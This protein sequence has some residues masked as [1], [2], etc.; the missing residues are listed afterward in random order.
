MNPLHQIDLQRLAGVRH[1]LGVDLTD[2]RALIVEL[3]RG[4]NPWNRFRPKFTV[5]KSFTIDFDSSTSVAERAKIL[6]ACISKQNIT[7]SFAVTSIQSLG[8]KILTTTIPSDA[9]NIDE[10]IK[11]HFEKLIKL[12]LS[13]DQISYQYEILNS[14]ASGTVADITF[15]RNSDIEQCKQL[16]LQAALQL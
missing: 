12:P 1:V 14:S 5:K 11:E 16:F 13:S 7:T 3:E 10:W 4:G 2:A 9:A 6:R 15:L 8:I